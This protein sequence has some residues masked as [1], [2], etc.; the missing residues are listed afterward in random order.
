ML[1]AFGK[2]PAA[3]ESAENPLTEEKIELGR[4]L[5]YETKLSAGKDISCNSCHKLDAYGVDGE[6]T[7]PG[8]K[9]QRGARNSPTVY[10]AAGHFVQFWDGRAKNVEEQAKGPILNP[11]EMA[12]PDEKAVLAALKA[13]KYEERFKKAFPSE[14]DPFTFDNVAKAIGAFERKLMTPSRWDRFLA[15]DASAI[16]E[17]EKAGFNKF[18]DSGC[19]ACH[20]GPYLGAQMYQKLGL[21]RPWPKE[22]DQGRFA[23][24]KQDSDKMMFKVPSLRNVK[25]T[26]PY[27]HDGSVA[28]IEEAIKLMAAHE[29]GKDLSDADVS[30]ISTFLDALTGEI[31]TAYAAPP[32]AHAAGSAKP[33][34]SGAR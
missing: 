28:T 18:I 4:A 34:A 13:A 16:S 2:V 25:K 15:G 7:S 10:N 19:N 12:M 21:A 29:V 8:H 23:I 9:K 11:V 14:K 17:A 27:F 6:K 30:S 1:V 5:Y 32:G 26:A 20:A 24:T 3:V 22:D 31:P 33:A